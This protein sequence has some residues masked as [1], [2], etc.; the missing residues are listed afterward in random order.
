MTWLD[1]FGETDDE[2]NK[3]VIISACLLFPAAC[4]QETAH[5]HLQW[6]R[7]SMAVRQVLPSVIPARICLPSPV[8]GLSP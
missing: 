7:W 6:F 3:T 1:N 8:T 4:W 5:W 2:K